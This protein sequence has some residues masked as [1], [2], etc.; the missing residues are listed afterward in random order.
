M[1][2]GWLCPALLSFHPIH[3]VEPASSNP[4]P[5]CPNGPF[6]SAHNGGRSA[7]PALNSHFIM[8][9]VR[10]EFQLRNQQPVCGYQTDRGLSV[11]QL[12]GQ[13]AAPF[14][15][16]T[17]EP[18]DLSSNLSVTALLLFLC[19][20]PKTPRLPARVPSLSGSSSSTLSPTFCVRFR[21]ARPGSLVSEFAVN[22]QNLQTY[23]KTKTERKRELLM[24]VEINSAY[25]ETTERSN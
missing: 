10:S 20:G 5:S 6:T 21:P 2:S 13:R 3:K 15:G 12:Q 19:P 24:T 22:R 18:E 16:W 11:S 4:N 14:M 8:Q 7:P 1:P 9:W 17:E 25:G 23:K